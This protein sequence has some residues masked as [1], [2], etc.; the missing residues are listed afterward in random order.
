MARFILF[1]EKNYVKINAMTKNSQIF[2]K[3]V[4]IFKYAAIRRGDI[5]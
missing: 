4:T 3:I 1:S 2:V 5:L